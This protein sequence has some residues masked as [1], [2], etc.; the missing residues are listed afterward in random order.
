VTKRRRRH[1]P[2]KPS[3][4]AGEAPPGVPLDPT[5][6]PDVASDTSTPR[7]MRAAPMPRSPLSDEEL[8]RLKS[9]ARDAPSP[10][11]VPAQED[12]AARRTPD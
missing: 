11:D 1:R 7:P 9:R 3:S 8:E 4:A 10:A 5:T 12:P 2:A 6:L